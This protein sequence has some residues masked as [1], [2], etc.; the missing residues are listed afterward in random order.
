MTMR[1]PW[2]R[3]GEGGGKSRIRGV[4]NSRTRGVERMVFPL[5][6]GVPWWYMYR[7]VHGPAHPK[8]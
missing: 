1:A 8:L 3:V 5:S 7:G 4:G 2:C 6:K